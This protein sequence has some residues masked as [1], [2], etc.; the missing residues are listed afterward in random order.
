[1][2]KQNRIDF[3]QNNSQIIDSQ[4]I[5]KCIELI[6]QET[7]IWDYDLF[8]KIFFNPSCNIFI[9]S[10]FY[11]KNRQKFFVSYYSFANNLFS[12]SFKDNIEDFYKSAL[13]EKTINNLLNDY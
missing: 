8:K 6:N 4:I 7:E 2:T 10:I 3:I 11:I 5:D 1:M 12:F 13:R 9:L